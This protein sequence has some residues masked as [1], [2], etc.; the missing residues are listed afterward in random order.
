[1]FFRESDISNIFLCKICKSKLIEP[2]TLSCGSVIC[3][4]CSKLIKIHENKYEC[5]VCEKEHI[6]TQNELP[7][8]ELVLNLLK[9]EPV[10]VTRGRSFQKLKS[11]I[12]STEKCCYEI[13]TCVENTSDYIYEYFSNLKND[14]QLNKEQHI[15]ELEDY[16]K[17]LSKEIENYIK[18]LKIK[19][20]D[21]KC[22]DFKVVN[23]LAVF[24]EMASNYLESN[25]INDDVV[26][27]IIENGVK[28][29]K[30][31]NIERRKLEAEIFDNKEL[32]YIKPEKLNIKSILGIL[33]NKKIDSEILT[34][35]Q[36][37][38]M[39]D[40]CSIDKNKKWELIYRG[41]RDDFSSD[42]FH[43]KCDNRKNTLTIIKSTN[44]Y[45]FGGYTEKDWSGYT[46]KKDPHA[47]LFSLVNKDNE[48]L[49]M[50]VRKDRIVN[51]IECD[52]NKG[53]CFGD[54]IDL[55]IDNNANRNDYSF[56]YLGTSY[57]HPK[58]ENYESYSFLSG[59]QNFRISEIEVFTLND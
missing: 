1:M 49:L 9:I 7:I 12:K 41:S 8:N 2:R 4:I 5:L 50:P 20:F 38:E 59:S 23:E 37:F 55:C 32:F 45:I 6:T 58:Y 29:I 36:Y 11:L 33:N 25:E 21:K 27:E 46:S 40:L 3:D 43:S 19:S 42:S 13:K 24:H 10:N 28:L 35:N 14:I 57:K 52:L 47:Y 18:C 44:Y 39:L 31:A 53:P 56:S 48:P 34:S 54:G 16:Q 30:K 15:L 17:S 22:L 26:D 51:S